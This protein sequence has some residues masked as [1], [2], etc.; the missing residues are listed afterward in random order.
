MGGWSELG[1]AKF[2]P[3]YPNYPNC[4]NYPNYPNSLGMF[5]TKAVPPFLGLVQ[6]LFFHLYDHCLAYDAIYDD[7]LH[8][9]MLNLSVPF[10]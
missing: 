8:S 1:T 7:K 2:Y 6:S 5:Q 3:N 4:P 10:E 9:S